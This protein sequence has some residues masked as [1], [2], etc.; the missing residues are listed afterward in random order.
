[1]IAGRSRRDVRR[2]DQCWGRPGGWAP[3]HLR[4][5][6]TEQSG[7]GDAVVQLLPPDALAVFDVA[8]VCP[9]LVACLNQP[10]EPRDGNRELSSIAEG[11]CRRER[12]TATDAASGY[13][14]GWLIEELIPL[15]QKAFAVRGDD[16]PDSLDRTGSVPPVVAQAD[17]MNP[18]D[19]P[20]ARWVPLPA[21]RHVRDATSADSLPPRS[22][23]GRG[24]RC[25]GP[26]AEL[27]DLN[28]KGRDG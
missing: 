26:H 9:L 17:G 2:F 13:L 25:P 14:S 6:E 10:V 28:G 4:V 12:S 15:S 22:S 21:E 8:M 5:G 20:S 7:Y 3:R 11:T 18:E 1:V 24:Q 23:R 16:A 27:M 19:R